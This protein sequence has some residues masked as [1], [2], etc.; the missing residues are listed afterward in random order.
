MNNLRLQ[1]V[2]MRSC[3]VYLTVSC[4]F[5]PERQSRYE[6]KISLTVVNAT[7]F[8]SNSTV[9]VPTPQLL[10]YE[11]E[12]NITRLKLTSGAVLEVKEGA[13]QID[14]LVRAA[15]NLALDGQFRV[16]RQASLG[17]GQ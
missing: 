6:P 17:T 7:D 12:L 3:F 15:N 10:A 8:D 11:Q 13:D 14:R 4:M 2:M 1:L 9:T 5:Y 16:D